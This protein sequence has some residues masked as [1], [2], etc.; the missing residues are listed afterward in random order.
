MSWN[1]FSERFARFNGSKTFFAGFS[2]SSVLWII[3]G[4]VGIDKEWSLYTLVLSILAIYITVFIQNSQNRSQELMEE[5]IKE[6]VKTTK[7]VLR[8]LRKIDRSTSGK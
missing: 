3:A 1:S 7:T 6:D 2:V 8:L 5:R 4:A